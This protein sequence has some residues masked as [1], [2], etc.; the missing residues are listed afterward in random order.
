MRLLSGLL[1]LGLA[2]CGDREPRPIP[3][4]APAEPQSSAVR[5]PDLQPRAPQ[6]VAVTVVMDVMRVVGRSES[7]VAALLGPGSCEDIHRARLCRYPPRDDEV[8]FVRGKADMITVQ[9][10]GAVIFDDGALAALG[11]A[12]A[13][14]EHRDEHAIRWESLPGLHEVTVF[15]APG[16]RVHYAYVKVGAH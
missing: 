8:M 6:P 12:P 5:Q 2:G 16:N 10:M 11:L 13:Q 4:P 3:I 14:P 1:L 7:E 15:P 9:G